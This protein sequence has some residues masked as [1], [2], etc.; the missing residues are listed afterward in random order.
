MAKNQDIGSGGMTIILEKYFKE[1]SNMPLGESFLEE[2]QS[3]MSKQT[4]TNR[5][6]LYNIVAKEPRCAVLL[7]ILEDGSEATV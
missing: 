2:F 4:N 6:R 7:S 5:Y 3:S 1:M